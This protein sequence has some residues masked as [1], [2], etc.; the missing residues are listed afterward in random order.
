MNEETINRI[1]MNVLLN[2]REAQ[3]SLIFT[4]DSE[5]DSETLN[6]LGIRM[7]NTIKGAIIESI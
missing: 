5:T 7:L 2:S 3:E 6:S 1:A 4:W